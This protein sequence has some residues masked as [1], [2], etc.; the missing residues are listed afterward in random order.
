MQE[1]NTPSTEAPKDK[2]PLED[3]GHLSRTQLYILLAIL[4]IAILG[5][6]GYIVWDKYNGEPVVTKT[7]YRESV[8]V[9]DEVEA[10]RQRGNS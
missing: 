9:Q 3:K 4:S 7:V 10:A 2:V 1:Q 6:C 8:E 5:L